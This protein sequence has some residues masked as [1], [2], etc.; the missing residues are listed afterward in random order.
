M[1]FLTVPPSPATLPITGSQQNKKHC[2]YNI[3][4]YYPVNLS[5]V[6]Q[7]ATKKC[8]PKVNKY[9][10]W[11]N[12][13]SLLYRREHDDN[14]GVSVIWDW[15]LCVIIFKSLINCGV[16]PMPRPMIYQ[17]V[18]DVSC[19][20]DCWG[21]PTIKLSHLVHL[22]NVFL[23]EQNKT[24]FFTCLLLFECHSFSPYTKLVFRRK[25]DK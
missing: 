11:C 8:P 9:L 18:R 15:F 2:H 20:K 25:T 4:V 6:A 17:W 19:E 13:P 22:Q 16:W 3:T 7:S 21:V 14:R 24:T 12:N 1:L 23:V 10:L 5:K